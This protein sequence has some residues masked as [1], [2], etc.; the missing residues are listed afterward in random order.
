MTLSSR[1][2]SFFKSASNSSIVALI[3]AL[4]GAAACCIAASVSAFSISLFCAS[5]A[6]FFSAFI[7]S[8]ILRLLSGFISIPHILWSESR[9]L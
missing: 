1:L 2:D 6:F 3:S 4:I 8:S 9:S 5:V 7:I